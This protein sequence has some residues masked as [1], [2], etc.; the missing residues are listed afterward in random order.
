MGLIIFLSMPI[1]PREM[2]IAANIL[3]AIGIISVTAATVIYAQKRFTTRST[4]QLSFILMPT[5]IQKIIV[6]LE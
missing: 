5:D 3:V 2:T 6:R 1:I 4:L